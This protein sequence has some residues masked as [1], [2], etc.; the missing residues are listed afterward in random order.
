VLERAWWLVGLA[1]IAVLVLTDVV[2]QHQ[3]NGV[4]AAGALVTAIYCS[5]GVTTAVALVALVSSFASGAW[6]DNLGDRAWAIR[7]AACALLCGLA[8]LTAAVNHRR[9]RQLERTTSLAQR[10]LDALAVELTGARTVGEVAEGFVNHAAT[11]LGA[12]SAMVLSLDADDVLRT[13]TWQG[14][15]G[16]AADQ[17]REV[18]LDS[19]LPGAVAAREGT[20]LHYRTVGDIEQAFPALVGYYGTEISL[21]VLPLRRE[22][23]TL[24]LLA[25]TF[26]R[27]SFTP[28]E[29]GFLH[30]LA[31][32]LASALV[33]AQEL[34]AAD[35]AA[36]RTTLLA[37]A[38][39]TLSRSLDLDATLG[40]VVRLLVPGLADWCVVQLLRDGELETVALQHRD[41][42]TTE[43]ALGMR[44]AFP[45]RMDAPTGGPNVVR[46]R[47]SEIYPYI[48]VEL[49]DASAV[50]E[51]HRA[52]LRRLGFTSAVVAPLVGRH[53]VLGAVTLIH[54]ESG[55]RYADEDLT[56]LE[57][58]AD[59]I[60]LALDTATTF[61]V[62]SERLAG[63]T[64]IAE[65]AQRAILAQPPP[66]IGPLVL[67][68]RYI[69]AAVEAQIGGDL[70]EVVSRRSSIRLLVGDVRG[71]GLGAVRT[72]TIVLG[73]FRAA[74][75]GDG[76]C[77]A[78][79]EEI[80][81][82]L[83]HYLTDPE[84]FVTGV[85]VDVEDDGRFSI[86]CCGHPTPVL[87]TAGGVVHSVE[88]D[89]AVPLGLGTAPRPAYGRLHPGDRLLLYTDG[90][91]E[92][93]CD[94][95]AFVDP[96]PFLSALGKAPVESAL[97]G[98]LGSLRGAAGHS[99]GDD[100]A[101]LLVCYDPQP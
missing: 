33:R 86:V 87:V 66:R 63:V 25:L 43:W 20:D 29:D 54:A 27:G 7:F 53:D 85:L 16:D 2:S 76:D 90:L 38:S 71:K 18:P 94:D 40:E 57:E 55:R 19:D 23:R 99:L 39:M 13:V 49:V 42:E 52:I 41:P 82:R 4:F 44:D 46:T 73:E 9:R 84:D 37:E 72:A 28:A 68:A 5:V 100:L 8:V 101:L 36:L 96:M 62:Q 15:G 34:Q 77:A 11:T 83:E 74:A 6:N 98:L 60:A 91:I 89:H 79:A 17:F 78:V 51:E 10:V 75:A 88:V 47:R 1:V 61:E 70:Y 31:G 97:D 32:A 22:D 59:R 65:A 12:K 45:T 24:G 50:N 56:L 58:V 14:R 93:R 95:G 81:R 48:P 3:I 35:A 67:N 80:D 26:P 64:L 69:S 92:A 30:S 21:H